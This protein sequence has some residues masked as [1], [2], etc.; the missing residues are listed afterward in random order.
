VREQEFEET[1]ALGV[2]NAEAIE[3]TRRH[4]RNARLTL[5][6]GNSYGGSLLGVPLGLFEIRCEHAPPP[7]VQS[8]RATDL[9]IEFYRANCTSCGHR[10]G[11]G[12]L[13]NLATVSAERAAAEQARA[14]AAQRAADE[15]AARYRARAERR[16]LLLAGEGHV[17]RELGEALD[18]I[19]HPDPRSEP[20]TVPQQQAV[21]HILDAA[22]AAPAL[23]RPVLV[24]SLVELAT[25]TADP[26]ALDALQ[27]LVR[28]G[29][30]PPRQ[31]VGAAV[32]VLLQQRS[33]EAGR[34]FA[35]LEPDLTAA[36]VPEV[37][38]RLIELASGDDHGPWAAPVS[39]DGLLAASRV[40]LASVT[41]RIMTHLASDDEQTRQAGADAARELLAVDATRIVALGPPLAASIRGEDAGY[42]GTPHPAG[43]ALRALAEGC[44]GEPELTWRIV[45]A[46]AVA[47]SQPARDQLARVPWFVQRFREPWD[48]SPE[49]TSHAIA[50]IA[51]RAAGDWGD[52]SAAH[53]AEHLRILAREVPDA[54]AAHVHELLG[55]ILTLSAPREDPTPIATEAGLPTALHEMERFGRRVTRNACRRNLAEAIGRCATTNSDAV[56]APAQALFAASTGDE[57][58]D[59]TIRT[60]MLDVL[61]SAVSAETLRDILPTTFSALCD[62]DPAVRRSGIDLWAACARVA[63]TLPAEL[64]E[65]SVAL[66]DD[67]YVIV[68]RAM[69]DKI[70]QL[71]LPEELAPRLLVSVAAWIAAY[72]QP[73]TNQHPEVLESALWSLR[74]LA[75]QLPDDTQTTRWLTIAL[76][77]I[78]RCRPNDLEQLLTAWWPDELQTHP[79]WARTALAT[80]ASPDLVDYYN[81]RREPLLQ[82]LFDQ[83]HLLTGIPFADIEP[84]SSIHGPAHWWRALGTWCET[85]ASRRCVCID[86][87]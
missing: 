8:P 71:R 41:G 45:E 22:W 7:R 69:L 43:G 35:L 76:A 12:E 4:C 80:A 40:D 26:T 72:A 50:F 68:H 14:D 38:D 49:A 44:R 6:G 24:D 25:D 30:C 9:A 56:L 84:L 70:P 42:G 20:L 75:Q 31:A 60:A 55:A 83:P 67:T 53:S 2:A 59:R 87:W 86:V 85:T 79:V 37:A 36:D 29:R 3:L 15:R 66:L 1:A 27:A 28:A 54:V 58:Y 52:E 39:T 32:A 34:L 82:T 16:R 63:D 19:D 18:R 17:V 64:T 57:E 33:V 5:L 74:S 78:E 81:T 47:A 48:A 10:D 51:R 21:R 62:T 13:P 77:H 11:T 46:A 73:Q 61:E 23:F 65:L